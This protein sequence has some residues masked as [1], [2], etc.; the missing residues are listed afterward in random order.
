MVG[1]G[2]NDVFVMKVVSIG[3]VMGSGIDVVLEMVDVVFIYN[4]LCGLV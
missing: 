2:I 3:I 4:C 1:D